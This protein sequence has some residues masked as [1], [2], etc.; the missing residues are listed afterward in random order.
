M[1][2]NVTDVSTF[3]A[4]IVAVADGDPADGADF[5]V[6]TQ[7]L[8]NRTRYHQ[9]CLDVESTVASNGTKV[10]T[11]TSP[12]I[13]VLTGSTAHNFQLPDET[14]LR[15]G[16]T[17]TFINQTSGSA[18]VVK[19]SASSTIQ[20]LGPPPAADTF[21]GQRLTFCSASSGS[22]TGNWFYFDDRPGH[23]TA[24]IGATAPQAGEVG[25][26]MQTALVR[27]TK[28]TMTTATNYNLTASPLS[29]TKGDWD[30]SAMVTFQNSSG[31]ADCLVGISKTSLTLPADDTQ[32][33]PTSGEVLD[34]FDGSA[35][36]AQAS[37]S[38]NIPPFPVRLSATTSI[39]L[40][41][42]SIFSAGTTF[43][44][45]SLNARRPR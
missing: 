4:P 24:T 9:T 34:T 18:L 28:I 26:T 7:G 35:V 22:A 44:Y 39:Y 6:A 14:T 36:G 40:V 33:V 10:L 32:A 12:S 15:A 21:K 37:V 27:S 17:F 16:R 3:T 38:I 29:L 31:V 13:Q 43:A 30:V 11:A 1:P 41:V 25:E 20:S 19:D 8:S 5:L 2:Q 45:G 23:L 42:R